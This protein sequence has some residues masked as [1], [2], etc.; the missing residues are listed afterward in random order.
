[1]R[2]ASRACPRTKPPARPPTW[3]CRDSAAAEELERQRL[4]GPSTLALLPLRPKVASG[5]E[6]GDNSRLRWLD[7]CGSRAAV[8]VLERLLARWDS[9]PT[10]LPLLP[11]LLPL[12]QLLR[13]CSLLAPKASGLRASSPGVGPV[14]SIKSCWLVAV[15]TTAAWVPAVSCTSSRPAAAAWARVREEAPCWKELPNV[16]DACVSVGQ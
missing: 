1:M 15:P 11:L 8:P 6:V 5:V 13:R 14:G 12:L 3:R 4:S 7:D 9:E 2:P 10:L 16:G